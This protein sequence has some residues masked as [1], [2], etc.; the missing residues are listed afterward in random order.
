MVLG[1]HAATNGLKLIIYILETFYWWLLAAVVIHV[2]LIKLF[3][4]TYI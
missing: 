2:I 4:S 3:Y 1:V